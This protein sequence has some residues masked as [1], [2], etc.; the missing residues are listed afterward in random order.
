MKFPLSPFGWT[1]VA[2]ALLP[3]NAFTQTVLPGAQ[4][5]VNYSYQVTTNP[6]AAVGSVYAADG[7]PAGLGINSS[8]GLISGRPAAAGTFDGTVSV[9]YG[10]TNNFAVRIVVSAATGTP[11]ITSATSASG[12]VGMAFTYTVT[13][14]NSPTSFNL[15]LLP[16]GLSVGGTPTVPTIT[17]TPT[18]AGSYQVALSGINGSGT[19]PIAILN[20]TIAAATGTPA[21]TSSTAPAAVAVGGSLSYQITATN[22]PTSYAAAGLPVGISLN[23]STGLISGTAAVAGVHPVVITAANA[24]GSGAPATVNFTIGSVPAITSPLAASGIVGLAFS[25]A[26]QASNSPTSFNVGALP[27]GLT[28]NAATGLISGTPTAAGVTSVALS[29][30]NATGTGSTATL[31]ITISTAPPPPPAV[32][33][34]VIAAPTISVQPAN[35]SVAAGGD[36]TFS[37]SASGTGLS[38]QWNFNGS[39]IAGAQSAT[40][41]ITGVTSSHAGTYTVRVTN[42]GGTIASSGAVLTVTAAAAPTITLHP[43]AQTTSA[44]GAVTFSVV[45]AGSGPFTYQWLKDGATVAGATNAS[46]VL[47]N[48]TSAAA[49]S[50]T[51]AVSNNAGSTTSNA[52]TLTVG[53]RAVAGTYVGTFGGGGGT[54]ALHVRSDRTGI[55]LGYA[56]GARIGLVARN[57]VVDPNGRFSVAHSAPASTGG[58]PLEIAGMPIAAAGEYPIEGTIAADGQLSGSVSG[59]NL[60][61]S[62][63]AAAT[64]GPSAPVAGFYQAGAAGSSA[65]AFSIVSP[66][67]Q[68]FVLT[69]A[70]TMI[71]AGIGTV[72][73]DGALSVTTA[74]N[75]AI[76]GS[77]APATATLTMTVTPAT[78][79]VTTFVG[80]NDEA[81]ADVEKLINIST[82]SQ[83]SST[84]ALIAGFVITGTETKPVLI[85]AIGPTLGTAFNVSGA[86]SAAQVEVFRGQT[87]LA[88]G[89]DWGLPASAPA[90]AATAARVGAFALPAGSRDAALLMSL[91]P[92]AYTAV[93]TGQGSA[94]GVALVEVYD[95]TEGGIPRNQ[96][97]IN[98]AT[99]AVAGTAER[100]LIAG[101]V[102]RGSVPQRVLIRG[103]GPSLAQFGVPDAL[104]RPQL[105]L[106]SGSTVLAQNAGWST[107]TDAAAIADAGIQ[108]GAFAFS[109]NSQDAA[110]IVNLAP[111]AYT[112]EVA[113]VGGTTGTALVEVYEVR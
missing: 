64:T 34:I 111:G 56:S 72:G 8:S 76:R 105:S 69:Q 47:S 57:V 62:A 46:L 93:V 83:A 110:L 37:V 52:A 85:R 59:L 81:R 92:G 53:P 90:I 33:P 24:A 22:S 95:A 32:P 17:G 40:Y 55:F 84:S 66:A 19:G 16:P 7:L 113:G 103:A 101:F 94:S 51:V 21:I 71:D 26:I 50:Y 12:A 43:I 58:Q 1:V 42:A 20:I 5:G 77:I 70:G 74:A 75:A 98:V 104:A 29:A 102:I 39:A 91:E 106:Y 18:T 63:P 112:V 78:G 100:S 25:S 23:A 35:Q 96:R 68:I 89:T 60:A 2:L 10:S 79:G 4:V 107:S 27:A 80:A 6:P 13:A 67:G 38:F 45:A 82:R 41:S 99:R 28:V 11:A 54:F 9:T 73:S 88:V 109:L 48:L 36:V 49:G 3:L 97:I 86:L 31:V 65:Q 15:G 108:A 30:N 87:S 44:G 61:F 14:S